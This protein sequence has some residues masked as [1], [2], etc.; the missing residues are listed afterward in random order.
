MPSCKTRRWGGCCSLCSPPSLP[1][2]FLA[3]MSPI[4]QPG[5]ALETWRINFR[6]PC[7]SFFFFF[8]QAD[9]I[10]PSRGR[11]EWR[12]Y[13]S[14]GVTCSKGLDE[15]RIWKGK[16]KNSYELSILYR[17]CILYSNRQFQCRGEELF[18]Y[19]ENHFELFFLY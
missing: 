13:C 4:N 8:F 19:C 9:E 16:K 15:A 2:S 6:C 1:P 10:G 3:V 17:V 11:P 12:V 14:L 7:S 5:S 18:E